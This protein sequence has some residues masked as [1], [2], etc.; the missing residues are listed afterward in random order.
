MDHGRGGLGEVRQRGEEV[1]TEGDR[2]RGRDAA[3]VVNG[4]LGAGAV[5]RHAPDPLHEDDGQA[6]D[7]APAAEGRHAGK[8]RQRALD[9]VLRAERGET[10]L[11]DDGRLTRVGGAQGK[12]LLQRELLAVCVGDEADRAQAAAAARGLVGKEDRVPTAQLRLCSGVIRQV[13]QLEAAHAD[14]AGA[15]R[16][17]L[18]RHRTT[19]DFQDWYSE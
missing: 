2:D 8:A 9:V 16:A 15:G 3:L 12:E 4:E 1:A 14:E 7:H 6:L 18:P 5:E 11:G 19:W 17:P 10:G 13:R